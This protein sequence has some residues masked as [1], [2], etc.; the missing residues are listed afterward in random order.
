MQSCEIWS[1]NAKKWSMPITYAGA[2]ARKGV[3]IWMKWNQSQSTYA[4]RADKLLRTTVMI[5]KQLIPEIFC[6]GGISDLR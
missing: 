2:L 4:C 5:I 1:F 6:K 3:S